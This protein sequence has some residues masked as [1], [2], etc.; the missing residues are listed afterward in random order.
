M[1]ENLS[2]ALAHRLVAAGVLTVGEAATCAG[3][4]R[5]SVAYWCRELDAPAARRA[6]FSSSW[7]ALRA[8]LPALPDRALAELAIARG[9][10]TPV[11]I[12]NV[13]NLDVQVV[14][15]WIAELDHKAARRAWCADL[16]AR[17]LA[18]F[19]H[20][21]AEYKRQADIYHEAA[22]EGYFNPDGS[23]KCNGAELRG[24]KHPDPEY[25]RYVYY[26]KQRVDTWKDRK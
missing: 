17:E 4:Q 19:E 18:R 14:Y 12:A 16:W 2:R 26:G 1:T 24:L 11:E 15:R 20:E 8:A 25:G 3:V 21:R 22:R 13:L 5:A 10:G 23:W 9:V 7:S 6:Y